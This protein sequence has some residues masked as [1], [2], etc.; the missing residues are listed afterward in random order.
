VAFAQGDL[1][2][3]VELLG[4]QGFALLEVEG[5]QVFVHLD[6]LVDDLVVG[7]AHAGEGRH[8][9]VVGR[10]EAVDDAAP[11]AVGRL[12][13]RHSLPKAAR[14]APAARRSRRPARRCG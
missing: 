6:H 7:L 9:V 14:C 11:P 4:L 3:V 10:E 8:G 1:E 5:H 13:G 2:G 12:I